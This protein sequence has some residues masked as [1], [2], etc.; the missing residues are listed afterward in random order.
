ME[1]NNRIGQKIQD[2][3]YQHGAVSIKEASPR[4]LYRALGYFVREELGRQMYQTDQSLGNGITLVY[5][6]MEY[7]PGSILEKNIDYLGI[8]EELREALKDYSYDL[9]DLLY[10][11]GEIGLGYGDLGYLSNALLDTF[12]SFDYN[13]ISYGLLYRDGYFTQTIKDYEQVEEGDNWWNRGKNWLYKGENTYIVETGGKVNVSMGEKGLIFNQVDTNKLK[14]QYYDL[15]YVGYKNGRCQRLRLFDHEKLTREFYPKSTSPEGLR[16]RFYQEYLLVSG[17]ISDVIRQ[18]LE[19]NR[20]L[21]S[22][23]ENF[24]FLVMDTSLLI[25]IPEFMRVLVDK[26]KMEWDD[27]WEITGK[28]FFFTPLLSLPEAMLTLDSTIIR[29]WLPRLWMIV[30]EIHHRYVFSLNQINDIKEDEKSK[31]TILWEDKVRLVNIAKAG[32]YQGPPIGYPL[33]ISHRRWLVSGNQRLK[34]LLLETIGEGFITDPRKI[35]DIIKLKDD[36]GFKEK[37]EYTRY[38]NKEKLCRSVFESNRIILNPNSIFDGYLNTI[39]PENRQ[40]L[41]LLS[42]IDTYLNLKDNPNIDIVPQVFFIGGK[43]E[44]TN[45]SGKQLI[46]LTLRLQEIINKD[47]TIKDK[48]KIIFIPDLSL[49]KGEHVYPSM[50]IN[51]S[52]ITPSK[53]DL[54]IGGL[55]S[56]IN[57]AV[58]LASKDDTNLMI[59]EILGSENI[60]TFGISEEEVKKEYNT[61]SYNSHEIYYLNKDI[62]RAV[63]TLIG[64]E[65]LFNNNEFRLLYEL[66]IK[67]NDHNFVMRDFS[68]YKEARLSL[69]RD[70]L[71]RSNWLNKVISNISLIGEFSSDVVVDRYRRVMW[72]GSKEE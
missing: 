10:L 9:E 49:K 4:E 1:N 21:S 3:L 50:D 32:A 43:A 51:E 18:H 62:K 23:G 57:G 54:H 59:K 33:A 52:L 70:Y 36:S 47:I 12:A 6:S 30:E 69:E 72:H 28:M 39:S 66:L 19:M 67:Y 41:L 58:S 64:R 22:L 2:I 56:M 48:L 35:L 27:A 63:D 71:D 65:G 11:D 42:I 68:S 15:P 60:R 8:R 31:S 29:E 17:A 14:L 34:E 44:K 25:A 26:Y 38:K 37:L 20:E 40:L 55:T 5:L 7:L 61:K 16:N 53:G 46:R 13:A 45:L 24:M